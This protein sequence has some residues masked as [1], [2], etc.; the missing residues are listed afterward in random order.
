MSQ[1][2]IDVGAVP[3]DGTGDPIRDSFIKVNDNFTELYTAISGAG[4]NSTIFPSIT[5]TANLYSNGN[6]FVNDSG[7][8]IFNDSD[9]TKKAKFNLGSIGSGATRTFTLPDSSQT[10]VGTSVAQTLTNKTIDGAYN[11]ISN[12][13]LVTGII[14][15]LGLTNGGTGGLLTYAYGGTGISTAPTDGQLLIGNG[16]NYTAATITAGSGISVTN[17]SGAIT[18]SANST[19]SSVLNRGNTSSSNITVNAVQSNTSV[20]TAILTSTTGYIGILQANTNNKSRI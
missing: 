11:T 10:L 1:Q 6:T 3:N 5:V 7:F 13:S 20:N 15:S 9:S 8:T 16:T 18:I 14:G 17:G 2:L 4:G 12:I 19:L